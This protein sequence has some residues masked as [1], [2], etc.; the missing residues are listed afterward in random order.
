MK[1]NVVLISLMFGLIVFVSVII[2]LFLVVLFPL[3]YKPVIEKYSQIYNLKPEVV[4][5]VINV[6]S[7]FNKNATSKVGAIGLMQIMPETGREI[8]EKLKIE[9]Y[10]K[11]LLYSPEINIRFGC[12]YLNY[13]LNMFDG[14][15][16]N[17]VAAYN[18]G[19]NKVMAWLESE[20]YSKNGV[21]VE[22]PISE[23]KHYIR[24]FENNLS[25]YENRLWFLIW[26]LRETYKN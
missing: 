19:F 16:T 17:A 21:V 3:K 1:K 24:K 20:Q 12:F 8:A 14:N 10:T 23:T 5:A 13:L 18:A 15:L 11:E 26:I 6:E 9:N 7:G 22:P 4:C 25:V 2:I